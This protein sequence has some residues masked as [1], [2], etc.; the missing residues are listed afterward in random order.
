MHLTTV[1]QCFLSFIEAGNKTGTHFICL[2]KFLGLLYFQVFPCIFFLVIFF[3]FPGEVLLYFRELYY[4]FCSFITVFILLSTPLLY[5]LTYFSFP[6]IS[7]KLV[8][9][10]SGSSNIWLPWSTV[11]IGKPWKLIFFFCLLVFQ[12]MSFLA[13]SKLTNGFYSAVMNIEI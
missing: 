4:L 2:I 12:V 8:V 9:R 3:F 10:S 13:N 7:W 1:S 6:C 11:C 5:L